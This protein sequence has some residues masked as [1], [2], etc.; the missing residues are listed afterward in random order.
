MVV[1]P[2]AVVTAA[3]EATPLAT[4]VG[5]PAPAP[6]LDLAAVTL[7]PSDLA[8]I[9]LTG[10]GLANE[11][12]LRDAAT[13]AI[14][15]AD[16]DAMEV[17]ERLHSYREAGLQYRYLGSLLRP[18]VPLTH[19]P[20]GLVA[21]EQRI[22][23]AV[24]EFAT[25][26]GAA[27]SFAFLE[28]TLDNQ[29]GQDVPGTRIFGDESAL[30][31]STGYEIETGNPV[32]RLELAFRVD[33]LVA[34]VEIV[35]F[36]NIE[37]DVAT[38]EQLGD[39]LMARIEQAPAQGG[40]NLS[41]R[42]LRIAPL[43]PWIEKGRLRDFYIRLEGRDEPMFAQIVAAMRE[44]SATSP[45]ATPVAADGLL[46]EATYMF[47]T[48]VGEGQVIDLPLYVV[49]LNRYDSPELAAAA[50]QAVTTDLGPGY[51]NVRELSP[52]TVQPGD[53]SRWFAYRYEG[54]P[55]GPVRGHLVITRVGSFLIRL[56]A[57]GPVG[58]RRAGVTA[59][60]ER[61]VACLQVMDACEPIP[62]HD[63]LREL[64]AR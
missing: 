26:E 35:D 9:G 10:F 53:E 3:Q 25:A 61:Q 51:V 19:L 48:P 29:P 7:R 58:V 2:A 30:T 63:A 56:Q 43:V 22:S 31:R 50:L 24:S 15:Q 4:P 64:V 57:D 16:G 21:A 47:W 6:Q 5:T 1:A 49:W 32:Q 18:K 44:G 34:D 41:P 55:A 28:G 36:D 59:L 45:P 20:S 33:N 37:P 39:L 23:T 8:S 17:T 40:P 46:P 27:A 52:P 60:S 38:I 42:V 13:D 12:S 54:D 11:S 62:M 14:V